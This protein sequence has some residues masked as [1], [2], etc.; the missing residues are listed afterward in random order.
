MKIVAWDFGPMEWLERDALQKAIAQEE[1]QSHTRMD[2]KKL[3][4]YSASEPPDH[5]N[6]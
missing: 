1:A 2:L 5:D 4:I 3:T 6:I